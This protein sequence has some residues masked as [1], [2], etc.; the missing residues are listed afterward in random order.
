MVPNLPV[1]TEHLVQEDM[2][3]SLLKDNTA[4]L[5]SM[6]S[7]L[8]LHRLSQVTA[9]LQALHPVSMGKLREGS[10][11]SLR[12]TDSRSKLHSIKDKVSPISILMRDMHVMSQDIHNLVNMGSS[13]MA[14]LINHLTVVRLLANMVPLRE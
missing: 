11:D 1:N 8:D 10:T 5:L 12:A 9:S 14:R 13:S 6:V 2:D 4:V 7:R 3:N